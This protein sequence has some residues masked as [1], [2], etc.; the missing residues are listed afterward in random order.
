MKSRLRGSAWLMAAMLL[1]APSL[2]RAQ[3]GGGACP[4]KTRVDN[5]EDKYGKTTVV[6]PYRWLEDQDSKETRTWIAAQ[7]KC[8]EAA[9]GK[10]PGRD[11]IEKRLSALYRIDTYTLP[12]EQGGRYFFTKRLAGQELAQICMRRSANGADEVLVDPT[13]WSADHSASAII[14]KV[15]KDGKFLFY[16]RREGGQDE[17]TVHVLDIEAHKEL[18]DV[19]PLA[20]YGAVEPLNDHT[21][22]YYA[23]ATANGPRAYYHAMGAD[24][25]SDKLLFGEKLDKEKE[26]ALEL[27]EDNSYIYYLV[28]AGAG[29]DKTEVYLQDLTGER[30]DGAGGE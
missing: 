6:D 4:P 2:L 22:V 26:L 18:P 14:E 5:V 15:S 16:G 29:A 21:G 13:P 9:L 24:P 23:K 12:V 10:L 19:L 11:A 1:M 8:T 25:A 27:S 3:E 17:V 28:I 30:A 20:D 7:D